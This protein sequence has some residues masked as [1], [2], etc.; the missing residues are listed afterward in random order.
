MAMDLAIKVE[1]LDLWYGEKQALDSVSLDVHSR[2][3]TALIGPSGCG[4]STL[5]R[6]MNRM[7]DQIADCRTKGKICVEGENV[8]SPETDLIALRRNVGMVFQHPN[9]FPFSI[10]D[11][12]SYGPRMAGLKKR[13]LLERIVRESLVRASLYDEVK[14]R[15]DES[16]ETLSG[17]Q[18]QRLCIA[19]ALAMRPRI[20]LFDEPCSA[21]DPI[22]T[23]RIEKLIKD[24]RTE[25]TV[26]IVT[27]NMEQAKRISDHAAF[28]YL[29]MLVESAPTSELFGSPGDQRTQDYVRG[30]FS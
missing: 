13:S 6:C 9:P 5:L 30:R 3:V 2:S 16:A 18:Q 1:G 26:V 29:G 27:H 4:K 20:L 12:V 7:N 8:N 25:Y 24:L 17:G 23:M 19:R 22:A 28:L 11:N 15:L 10:F 14:D 21:L